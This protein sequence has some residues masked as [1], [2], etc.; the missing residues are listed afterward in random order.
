VY[1]LSKK[2]AVFSGAYTIYHVTFGNNP[3]QVSYSQEGC[4]HSDR[5]LCFK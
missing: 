4:A 2:N 1:I 5:K 3:Y